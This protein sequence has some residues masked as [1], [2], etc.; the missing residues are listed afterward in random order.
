MKRKSCIRIDLNNTIHCD[1]LLKILNYY[2][3]DNI[4]MGKPMPELLKPKIIEGLRNHAG[5]IGFFG[6]IDGQYAALANCNINFSTWQAMPLINIHDF[7]VSP[8]FRG[9][10][11]GIFLLKEIEEYAISNGFCRINLEVSHE[12]LKAQKLYIKAGFKECNPPNYFWEK[13][14]MDSNISSH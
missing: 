6:C 14:L 8:D 2:M 5:Y 13:D 12:N 10:G 9:T 1:N 3:E 4:G 11:M 7:V